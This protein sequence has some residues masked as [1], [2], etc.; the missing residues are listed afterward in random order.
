MLVSALSLC[1]W[2]RKFKNGMFVVGWLSVNWTKTIDVRLQGI[3]DA[4][5]VIRENHCSKVNA[6]A[7]HRS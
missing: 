2:K 7:G 1:E 3:V 4:Q 6:V 5:C